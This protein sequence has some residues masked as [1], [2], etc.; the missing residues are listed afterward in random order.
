[1]TQKWRCSKALLEKKRRKH[2]FVYPNMFFVKKKTQ[3]FLT[4]WIIYI[5][6]ASFMPYTVYKTTNG[7]E[8]NVKQLFSQQHRNCEMTLAISQTSSNNSWNCSSGWDSS[9]DLILSESIKIIIKK[10]GTKQSKCTKNWKPTRLTIFMLY[11]FG[12]SWRI[13]ILYKE[14]HSRFNH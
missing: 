5:L 6:Y 14:N 11:R 13:L 7:S 8:E 12:S 9:Y 1:M 3:W 10:Q 2:P 4:I